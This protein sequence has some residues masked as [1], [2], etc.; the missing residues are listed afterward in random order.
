MNTKQL[1]QKDCCFAVFL[2]Y[3]YINLFHDNL[4]CRL[5]RDTSKG[6]SFVIFHLCDT[7]LY[8]SN[9]FADLTTALATIVT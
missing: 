3:L 6:S 7:F 2:F 1:Q 4:L 9:S 5:V 8:T